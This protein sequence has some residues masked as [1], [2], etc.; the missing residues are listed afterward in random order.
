MHAHEA[1]TQATSQRPSLR[2]RRVQDHGRRQ[3]IAI[4]F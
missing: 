4:L 2:E 1:R 3:R